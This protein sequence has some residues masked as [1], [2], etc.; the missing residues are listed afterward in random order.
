MQEDKEGI[1]DSVDTVTDCLKIFADILD[2][3]GMV[4]L[5]LSGKGM[6]KTHHRLHRLTQNY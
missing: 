1:F 2:V 5:I 3:K 6:N 4:G